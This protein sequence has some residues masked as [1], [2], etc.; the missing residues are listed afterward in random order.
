MLT[1]TKSDIN[2]LK[3][4]LME[5]IKRSNNQMFAIGGDLEL[6]SQELNMNNTVVR[7]T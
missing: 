2:T 5:A 4:T 3:E 1:S 7:F 6:E